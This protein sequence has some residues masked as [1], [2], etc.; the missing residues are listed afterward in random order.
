MFLQIVRYESRSLHSTFDVKCSCKY[1]IEIEI[2][3]NKL[4]AQTI[5]RII[6]NLCAM[7][8][9]LPERYVDYNR[10]VHVLYVYMRSVTCVVIYVSSNINNQNV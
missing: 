5:L 2:R 3:A 7:C 10:L 8:V 9:W 4:T 6:V 1:I